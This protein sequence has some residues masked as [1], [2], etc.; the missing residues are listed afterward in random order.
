MLEKS[1]VPVEGSPAFNHTGSSFLSLLRR[2]GRREIQQI[3]RATLEELL[4]NDPDKDR[5][6]EL[7][8]LLITAAKRRRWDKSGSYWVLLE[9]EYGTLLGALWLE[10]KPIAPALQNLTTRHFGASLLFEV[11]REEKRERVIAILTGG[12][13]EIITSNEKALFPFLGGGH[14][15]RQ[16]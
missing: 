12:K 14:E 3:F 16:K 15:K 6:I 9:N 8:Q 2:L 4:S 10:G 13:L 5:H 1:S 7:L 11:R